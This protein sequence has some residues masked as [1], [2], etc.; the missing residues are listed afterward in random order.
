MEGPALTR[1]AQAGDIP[2]M[3]VKAVNGNISDE[4][5]RVEMN[6][7]SSQEHKESGGGAV[8]ASKS[9]SSTTDTAQCGSSMKARKRTKTG[10]LSKS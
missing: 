1:S 9:A 8:K 6:G 5:D 10:C 4:R 7:K 2:F 3:E